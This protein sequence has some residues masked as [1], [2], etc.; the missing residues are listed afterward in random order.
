MSTKIIV[1]Y[2]LLWVSISCNNGGKVKRD[3]VSKAK[4]DR[5]EI[6]REV[7]AA[8]SKYDTLKLYQLIDT[9]R[10]FNIDDKE[11]FL[12]NVDYVYERL[13]NCNNHIDDSA[14]IVEKEPVHH[15]KYTV[16][17]CS[18]PGQPVDSS[19]KLTFSFADYRTDAL[20]DYMDIEVRR[21]ANPTPTIP[22][23]IKN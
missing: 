17:F 18:F 15:T 20:I 14:I 10:L 11:G 5:Y 13:R 21:K 9:S 22:A 16:V 2:A 23:P 8:I 3:N 1:V 7:V 6:I 19:F 12:W 4:S